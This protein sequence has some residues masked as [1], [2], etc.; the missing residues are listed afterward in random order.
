MPKV[1]VSTLIRGPRAEVYKLA[2]DMARFPEFMEDVDEVTVLERSGNETVTQWVTRLAG[3][4]FAWK[5]RDIF[6]DEN[7]HIRYQQIEG[8][9]KKFEGE[10]ILEE[11]PEGTKVTL[12]VDFEIGI[13][14]F[15]GILEPI[16]K[17]KVRENAAA[18]LEGIRK[19]IEGA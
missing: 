11:T 3:R 9:L 15:A 1:E 17:A 18:M 16:A 5:E 6:D 4:R 7:F 12:T 14:M 13:P 8:D 19:Q 2:S 10:W